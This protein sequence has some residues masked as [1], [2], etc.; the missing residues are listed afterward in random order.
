MYKLFLIQLFLVSFV[1]T[2]HFN[3]DID[4]TGESTLFIFTDS[5]EGLEVGD[6]LGVFDSEGIIDNQGNVGEILVGAGTWTGSQLE[7][8]A[9]SAVDL[10][11]FGGPILPGSVGGNSMT[12]KVWKS[13]EQIEYNVTYAIDSG[14]GTFN[15]LFS[16][17]GEIIFEQPY[18]NVDIADTGEST[19]FIFQDVIEGLELGDQL[20]IFDNNGIIDGDGNTGSILVGAGTWTGSQLEVTAISAVDLSQFSG[21]IL[22]GAVE[23]N[24]MALKVWDASEEMEYDVTYGVF[25]GSGTFDGLFT[26]VNEIIFEEPHFSV[27]IAETGESTLFIF[28]EVI[29]N[30]DVGDELGIFDSNGIL[31]SDGNIGEILVGSGTWNGSQLE[32]TAILAVD[33]S[34]FGGPILPGAVS[35]NS[36]SLRVWDTSEEMEYAVTYNISSGSGTFDGLFSAIDEIF[37]EEPPPVYTVAINEFFFRANEDVPDYVELFNF[38]SED[39]DLSGWSLTDGEDPF[40]GSFDDYVLEAGS[41]VILATEDDPFFNEDG[42]EF[43]S[44]DDLPNS[45]NFDISL[46]TSSDVIQLFDA[47]GNE[48]DIVSY[49]NDNGWPTGNTYRGQAAE[50]SDPFSDNNDPS[51]WATSEAE[52]TYMYTEDGDAGEDFG[53]PGEANSNYNPPSGCTDSSACNY[54]PNA[55][56]DDGSCWEAVDDCPCELGEGAFED[57]CGTCVESGT[58]PDD[59]LGIEDNEIPNTFS[60][61]QNYPNPFNPST[62][63]GFDVP[64][65]SSIELTIYDI[66]G[67]KIRT[68]ADQNYNAGHY[69]LN[70]DGLN[71][72]GEKVSSGIYIYQL[73]YIDGILSNK[74]ILLR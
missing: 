4:Q 26:A 61:M 41:Y 16:S 11:Q 55:V 73:K 43:Y 7:V 58:N 60:L 40:D 59:C 33:L 13:S 3:V 5:I 20:G 21:P 39:V 35:G 37:F 24:P 54:D 62:T 51:N 23:G 34:Q 10:S 52:G 38:G 17:I 19:L 36:M 14:T 64:E 6:E 63:I 42:D 22:P 50:L 45:L 31:D 69:D 25:Q 9:I 18:Y 28:T 48:V 32:I 1:F 74:M 2:Q 27:D 67:N 65:Y 49:D 29:E 47:D 53:T 66:L 15:G 30:L 70:W 56:V 46:S 57:D 12:L 8:V 44:G 68:L 71:N 72:N